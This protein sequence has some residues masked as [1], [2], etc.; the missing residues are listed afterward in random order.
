MNIRFTPQFDFSLGVQDATTFLLKQANEL[1]RG[2]NLRFTEEVGAFQRRLGF[3]RAGE[4]FATDLPPQGGIIAKFSTGNK[5]IVAVNNSGGTAT[6]LRVQDSDTGVWSDLADI[7][8]WPV[9]SIIFFKYYLDEVYVSGFDPATGDPIEPC[10]IDKDLDVS[11]TR[12]LR[13][14]PWPYF[15]EEYLGV[16]YAGNVTVNGN[17]HKDRVYKS[18]PPLGAMTFMQGAQD[19][20]Y[21]D[22][23]LVNQVPDMTSNTAPFGVAAASSENGAGTWKAYGAFDRTT[24]RA[25]GQTWFTE[26]AVLTGWLRYDFGAGNSKVIRSYAVTGPPSNPGSNDIAAAPKT[27]TFQG[28]NDASSWTTLDTQTNVPSW[29]AG[30]KRTYAFSNTTAY[31]YYRIN[32]TANQGSTA[33]LVVSELAMYSR[34][35]ADRL[36]EFKVDSV[37]YLK[38]GEVID[39]YEAGTETKKFTVTVNTVD[40]PTNTFTI[41]P[42]YNTAGSFNATTDALE[43]VSGTEPSLTDIATGDP[44][45]FATAGTMPT[46]LSELTTYYAIRVAGDNTKI[47]LALTEEQAL[48]NDYINFTTNGSGTFEMEKMYSV[49][50]NDEIWLTGTKG[51]LNLFWN[52]DYPNE[53]N[54]EFL[55]LKPGTD[56]SN[57]LT[58][59]RAS[60]NRLFLFTKNSGSRYDG[61]NLIVFNHS[62]GCI[63]HRSLA[64][65]DDDWLL[66][67]DAKGNVRARS[68]N[69]GAQENISRAIRNPIMRK[70]TQEQLKA[71]STGIVD[72]VA[73]FN[74]GQ[75]DGE[76]MRVCYDFESN[77]W[78]PEKLGYPAMIQDSDDHSGDLKPYFFS[79]NGRLYMDETGNKDDDKNI[80]FEAGTGKDILGTPQKKRFYGILLFTRN[81]NGLRLQAAVDGGQMKTIGRIEGETCFMKFPENGDSKLPLGVAFD[82]QVSGKEPGDPPTVDGAVVYWIP[83]EDV[84]SEKR[85]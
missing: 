1:N 23:T 57:T 15:F 61:N 78:S 37:R 84:P 41:Y 20:N 75:I 32:I 59:M 8:T 72:Q 40:K 21:A 3:V 19:N 42:L 68:E 60:A 36:I 10:N 12:N 55:A 77:T 80:A 83:E 5:R 13:H 2:V 24:I 65:I 16:L 31:R 76:W 17:R 6:I 71:V 81:C 51:R 27:W 70:L 66:W 49:E 64:N 9:D 69:Q 38:P 26:S 52:T 79:N 14:C 48:I 47:R 43:F 29:S 54:A 30:E 50:D 67:V 11:L 73:K 4:A 18:S 63:S 58:G 34:L 39:V 28:S 62:V 33:F 53:E 85:Q 22:E 82:W 45:R 35:E 25:A 56:G 7:P 46:G 44:I 74:L